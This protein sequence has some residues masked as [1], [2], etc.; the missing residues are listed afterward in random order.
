M[1]S[2]ELDKINGELVEETGPVREKMSVNH[3]SLSKF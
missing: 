3:E 1:F 2:A